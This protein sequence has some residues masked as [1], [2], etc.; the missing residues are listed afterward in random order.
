MKNKNTRHSWTIHW[1]FVTWSYSWTDSSICV[2]PHCLYSP[3]RWL[4]W[5]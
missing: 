3:N 5:L 2:H 1:A 4:W